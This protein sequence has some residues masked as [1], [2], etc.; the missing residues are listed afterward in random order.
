M[1]SRCANP[2]CTAQLRY[3][4]EGRLFVT[5]STLVAEERIHYVWLCGSCCRTMTVTQ[6]AKL[7][8]LDRAAPTVAG[9]SPWHWCSA[10]E[11]TKQSWK[12]AN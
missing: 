10:G 5:K 2:N 8:L 1:V 6:D 4:H 7:A 9:N 12:S 11:A 3:L